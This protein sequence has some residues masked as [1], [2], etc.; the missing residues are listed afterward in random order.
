MFHHP[1]FYTCIII[2]LLLNISC[3]NRKTKDLHYRGTLI[4]KINYLQTN[5]NSTISKKLLPQKMILEFDENYS[6]ITIEG[7]IGFFKLMNIVNFKTKRCTTVLEIFNSRYV[8][9][10]GKGSKICCFEP[11]KKM[12]IIETGEKKVIYGLN[13]Y[14]AK[15]YLPDDNFD[16]YYTKDIALP[17]PNFNN[18]YNKID[19][20]LLEFRLKMSGTY[21]QFILNKYELNNSKNQIQIKL[22]EKYRVVS[23]KELNEIIKKLLS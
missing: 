21:M 7:F 16:I 15:I 20:V 5:I 6:T 9:F 23:R 17:S 13:A 3:N 2:F 19:G 12:K 10:G 8:S 11:M 14:K 4:Y 1:N 18:D 22:P